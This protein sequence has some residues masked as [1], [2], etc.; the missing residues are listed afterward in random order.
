[1]YILHTV[2]PQLAPFVDAYWESTFEQM[3]TPCYDE[4]FVAQLYPNIIVNLSADYRRNN[5]R[6]ASTTLIGVNTAPIH[7]LHQSTNQLFGIRFKPSGLSVFSPLG[8]HE[9]ADASVNLEDIFGQKGADLANKISEA[10]TTADRIR[11]TEGFLL[12]H[13]NERF[14]NKWRFYQLAQAELKQL[15]IE[16]NAIPLIVKKM[17]TTQRTFD[18]HFQQILG[19]SPKKISRLLR[20]QRAFEAMHQQPHFKLNNFNFYDLGYYDQA[21]FSK[22]FKEFSGFAPQL[23][24]ASPYFVQ[25]LQAEH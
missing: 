10:A 2:H 24:L 9:I 22:E 11:I 18:R 8:L 15:C 23:Y 6:I 16:P 13:I 12:Q 19:L 4:L 17:N 3:L 20:F 14:L 21:H 25:N 7:F 1:M 5:E